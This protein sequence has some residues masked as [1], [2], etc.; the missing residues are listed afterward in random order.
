MQN[1]I[2]RSQ[3][4]LPRQRGLYTEPGSVQYLSMIVPSP[5]TEPVRS[6]LSLERVCIL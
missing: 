3:K 1:G 2:L 5:S 6:F 4:C